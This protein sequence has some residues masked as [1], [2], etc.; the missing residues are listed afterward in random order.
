MFF[1]VRDHDGPP[2]VSEADE[3]GYVNRHGLS[4]KVGLLSTCNL[5]T[6]ADRAP[7]Y[8]RVGQG[9]L[10]KAGRQLYRRFAMPQV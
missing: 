5:Y 6:R 1:T 3:I 4:R 2:I 7:A 8:L 10:E 9:Q